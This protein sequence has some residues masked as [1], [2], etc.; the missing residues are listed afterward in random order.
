MAQKLKTKL[1]LIEYL[2]AL[3]AEGK[4][5]K[6]GWEGGGDS[7]WCWFEIDGEQV[8]D[9][10]HDPYI[11]TLLDALYDTL[12]YGSWAGEF[13]ANG[14]AIYD[15]EQKAFVGTDY[16]SEDETVNYECD[17]SIRVPKS[18]W[19]DSMEIEIQDED[20]TVNSAFHIRN[21]F[22]TEEHDVFI[23]QFDQEFHNQV[24]EVVEKFS[25]DPNQN[26]YRSMWEHYEFNRSEFHE[27][28]DYLVYELE[29]IGIGTSRTDDKDVYLELE[30][31]N[32]TEDEDSE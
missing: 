22:L 5:I 3:V 21:G 16:Y 20:A 32:V 30:Y 18:L 23:E 8:S 15:P 19:F 4:E 1:S 26:D 31:L 12:D 28:G 6:M 14:Y 24:W 29:E 25:D 2:D 13:S 7:G 10:K 11:A 27:D 17:L 9:S